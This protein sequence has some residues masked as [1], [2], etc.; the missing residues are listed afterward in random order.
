MVVVLIIVGIG[1][2]IFGYRVSVRRLASSPEKR[3]LRTFYTILAKKYPDV[4]V[5]SATG[6]IELAECTAD[7][8]VR[9]FAEI[10]LRVRLS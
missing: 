6:L 7:P 4:T 8:Y 5:C 9:E 10:L 2:L 1:G 3:L